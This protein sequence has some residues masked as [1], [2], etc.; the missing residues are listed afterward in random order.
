MGEQKNFMN[1]N[2]VKGAHIK[3][4]AEL[5]SIHQEVIN[6]LESVHGTLLRRNRNIQA[7]GVFGVLKWNRA[8]RKLFRRGEKNVIFKLSLIFVVLIFVSIITKKLEIQKLYKDLRL[9]TFVDKDLFIN[10]NKN[11]IFI[12]NIIRNNLKK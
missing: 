10:Y 12:K 8:Y 4:N 7:E 6:N 11:N 5:I 1:V 2:H 9:L 3:K